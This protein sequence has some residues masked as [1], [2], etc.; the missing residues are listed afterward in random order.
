MT[1]A[2]IQGFAVQASPEIVQHWGWFLVFGIGLLALGIAAVTRSVT[3]TIASMVFF[4]WLLLLASGIEIAQAIMVGKWAG[5]FQHLL[6]AILF[7]VAGLLLIIRPAVSA[8]VITLF[9]AMIFLIGG[10]FQLIGSMIVAYPGWGWQAV[11]GLIT[12]LLGLLLITGWPATGLWVIGLFIGI[13]LIV[14]GIAW[15]ALALG[16]RG[17]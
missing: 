3:A 14:Y 13:N 15:I 6:A 8:E 5:L 11:D 10:L 7:G 17:S 1:A 9:M 2:D 16:L 12:F 4:G